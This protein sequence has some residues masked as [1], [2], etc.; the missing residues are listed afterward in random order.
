MSY[1]DY[2]FLP[3][4]LFGLIFYF[5]FPIRYRWVWLLIGS[6]LFFMT[7]GIE[8]LP[9]ILFIVFLVW[10]GARIMDYRYEKCDNDR[11]ALAAARKNNQIILFG[12]IAV[13]LL[14]FI[15][16]KMQNFPFFAGISGFF[17]G[18]YKTVHQFF[19]NIPIL[20]Y[21]VS[22]ENGGISIGLS[23]LC[24]KILGY[25]RNSTVFTDPNA[26]FTY[27]I[28]PVGFSYYILSLLGY[29]ADVYWRKERAEM[30]YFKLLLFTIYF[31]KILEGPI[32]KHLTVAAR[33][34][35]GHSF[36]FQRVSFGLQ[37]VVWGFFK[38]WVIADRLKILID[39]VFNNYEIYKGSEF[40]V[41][42]VFSAV[43]LYCDFSGCMDMGL[44][45]SECF[46]V[47]LEENF[48]HP[49][50]SRSSAEF[51]RRWHISLGT[52]FKDYIYMPLSVSPW[53]IR[54][55]GRIRKRF[56]KRAGKTFSIVIPL[57]VV[58]LLTGLW[59]GTGANYMVWGL[60]WGMLIIIS[61][62]LEPETK[63]LTKWLKINTDMPEYHLF[64]KAR[65]FMLFVISRIISLPRTME[66]T[67]FAFRSIFTNFAPWKLFDGSLFNLGIDRPQFVVVMLA[68]A[69]LAYVSGKQEKGVNVRQWIADRPLVIR[70]FIYYAAIFIVLIFGAYGVGYDA[71]SFVYMAY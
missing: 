38:K 47:I 29:L 61:N 31:P 14:I 27:W 39:T 44:G 7:W 69:L 30:N 24:N 54:L 20:N 64:Q 11:K 21:F 26:K 33:L 43:Q 52:W 45:I 40:L 18:I 1:T 13:L 19:L 59:H 25:Q 2:L 16:I 56:G 49:F 50:S 70:W 62:V 8:L 22:V 28:I 71:S 23:D 9:L 10:G 34:N 58:W 48:N 41:A 57:A 5:I 46:G 55:T 53:L 37:R 42:A 4:T 35:E 3:L 17:S 15:F 36:D 65:T 66:V 63:K 12:I 32:S 60:Y 51:W 67:R 6:L 68:I